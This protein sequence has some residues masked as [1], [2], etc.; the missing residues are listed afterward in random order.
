MNDPGTRRIDRRLTIVLSAVIAA[1]IVAPVLVAQAV[2]DRLP[3]EVARHWGATGQVTATWTLPTQLWVVGA[4]TLL[5]AGAFAA[6]AAAS[7]LPTFA[8]RMLAG[9][10]AWLGVL[11]AGMQIGAVLAH[12]DLADPMQA[13]GPGPWLVAGTLAGVVVGALVAR[14]VRAEPRELR[15]ATTPPPD[16]APRLGAPADV[17]ASWTSPPMVSRALAWVASI[18]AVAFL[19]GALAVAWSWLSLWLVVMAIVVCGP[20]LVFSRCRAT[21]DA[22]AL[23]VRAAGVRLLHVP[24]DE[25]AA[26]QVLDNLNPLWEFGGWGLRTDLRGRTGVITRKGE[27]LEVRRGDG[28]EIVITVDEPR[29]AA[30]LLNTLADQRHAAS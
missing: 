17:P 20:M 23:V 21:I 3:D 13:P 27:A 18:V 26:A 16:G 2:G 11:L 24:I 7:R 25:V 22:Q 6:G 1:C 5:I 29:A 28:S 19:L 12:V 9:C 15:L 14:L 30:S 10:A 4:M 8:R